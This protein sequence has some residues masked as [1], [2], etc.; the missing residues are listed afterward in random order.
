[1]RRLGLVLP[2]ALSIT[3]SLHAQTQVPSPPPQTARQ[4]LIEMFLGKNDGAFEKHLPDVARTTLI[5]KGETPETSFVQQ[6]AMMMRQLAA[7]GEHVETFDDGPMILVTEHEGGNHR[8]VEIMVEHDSFSGEQ[9]EIELSMKVYL[10]GEL[11]F[12]LVIPR[13]IF[14]M[15]QEKEIWR[16]SEVTLAMHSPLTDLDYLKGVHKKMNEEDERIASSR[17]SST[18]AAEMNYASQ[19]ADHA[20]TCNMSA[21]FANNSTITPTQPS[22][23]VAPPPAEDSPGYHFALAGCDGDPATKFQ[24]T[25]VPTESDSGMKAFCA[26]ESGALR[27]DA[28]GKAATC[29]SRG[30]AVKNTPGDAPGIEQ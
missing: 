8:K 23:E 15:V 2:A 29:L 17:M 25:A 30:E 3:I 21:L 7:Q 22:Q 4:A 28:S 13:I 19:R 6:I 14:S 12:I 9:D 27:S 18:I 10:N 26:D 1:M 5:R 11:Q 20:Y 24:L 16:L